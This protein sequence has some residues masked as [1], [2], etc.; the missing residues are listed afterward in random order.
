M[1][2]VLEMER[3]PALRSAVSC[4]YEKIN[5]DAFKE[6]HRMNDKDFSRKRKLLFPELMLI[7]LRGARRGV[8]T[9]IREAS[10]CDHFDLDTCSD[11]AFCKARRKINYTAFEE[12]SKSIAQMLC[13][14]GKDA[15]RFHGY[16]VWAI[17][18][19]RVNLPTNEQTL[20]V[21]GSEN[22]SSGPAA[23]SLASCLYDT[24][25]SVV[26]DA[27]FERHNANERA[28]AIKHIDA[29]EKYCDQTNTDKRRELINIAIRKS[30]FPQIIPYFGFKKFVPT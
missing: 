18:G 29:L 5:S 1:L 16:R 17:D 20:D 24:L 28:L 14:N 27:C 11:A 15:L 4:V 21:F 10:L 6:K 23:Q 25:N 9:A 13:E 8:H 2:E 19:T 30:R 22:F 3:F 7:I 26:L 12:L